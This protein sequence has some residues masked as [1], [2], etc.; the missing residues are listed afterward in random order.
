MSIW[1]GDE[2]AFKLLLDYSADANDCFMVTTDSGMFL[3][4]RGNPSKV[5]E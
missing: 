4:F 2:A 3:C 1:R 5:V